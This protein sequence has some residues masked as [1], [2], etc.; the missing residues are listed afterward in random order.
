MGCF[1]SM[2]RLRQAPVQY[3]ARVSRR[4]HGLENQYYPKV[5][6]VTHIKL[7]SPSFSEY[8]VFVIATTE[9]EA[10]MM[11]NASQLLFGLFLHIG[12][13]VA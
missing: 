7:P 13:E 9:C 6:F 10:S 8:V 5:P 2:A 1:A 12:H 4:F 3:L 11:P